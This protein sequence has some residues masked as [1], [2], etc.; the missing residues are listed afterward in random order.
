MTVAVVMEFEGATLDQYDRVIELMGFE[1]GGSGAPG[2]LFH[3]V[4][5]MDNGV[6]VT[7]VWESREQFERFAQQEIGP[8]TQKV[9]VP[10]APRITFFDVHN[11]LTAG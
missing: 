5:T 1:P 11:I 3:W 6:Q 7:D 4:T 9:G 10:G 8:A 2:G